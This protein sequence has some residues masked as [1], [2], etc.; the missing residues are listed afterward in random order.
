MRATLLNAQTGQCIPLDDPTWVPE[1]ASSHLLVGTITTIA[2]HV[3][4][5][6]GRAWRM[7]MFHPQ[8]MAAT[9]MLEKLQKYFNALNE[10]VL[11]KRL[12]TAPFSMIAGHLAPELRTIPT[13]EQMSDTLAQSAAEIMLSHVSALP[14]RG[15]LPIGR[16]SSEGMG[17]RSGNHGSR[18]TLKEPLGLDTIWLE[19]SLSH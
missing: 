3:D 7:P 8:L 12:G 10:A 9:A 16:R 11:G 4:C 13:R 14:I 2:S 19:V 15:L 1:I 5:A 17:S 18:M 6:L